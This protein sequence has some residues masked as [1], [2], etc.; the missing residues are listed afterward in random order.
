MNSMTPTLLA[1]LAIPVT[2]FGFIPTQI[3]WL[4]K[5]T[6]E[7][8]QANAWPAANHNTMLAWCS[9]NGYPVE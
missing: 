7:Q 3:T 8:C 5:A 4:D 1:L 6:A 9:H 2:L